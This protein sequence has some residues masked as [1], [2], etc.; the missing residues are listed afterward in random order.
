MH[1]ASHLASQTACSRPE[2]RF[3]AKVAPAGALCGLW[4]GGI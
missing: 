2:V 4:G 1:A 3:A